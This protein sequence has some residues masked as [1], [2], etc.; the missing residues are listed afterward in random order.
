MILRSYQEQAITDARQSI[1]VGNRR[2]IIQGGCGSG[3]TIIAAAMTKGALA[4]SKRVI[5]LVHYR[6]LAI[7]ALERFKKLV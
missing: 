6:Q 3:K 7:Q 1:R 4:K 5:Y 2:I